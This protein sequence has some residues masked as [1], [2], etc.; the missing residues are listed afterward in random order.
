MIHIDKSPDAVKKSVHDMV[1][2]RYFNELWG[3]VQY[4]E[5][6]G[7]CLMCVLQVAWSRWLKHTII[8]ANDVQDCIQTSDEQFGLLLTGF[9]FHTQVL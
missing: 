6:M 2:V 4:V 7:K 9:P 1:D 8:I 3:L 5:G